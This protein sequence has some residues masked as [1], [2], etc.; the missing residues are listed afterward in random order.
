LH[1][2]RLA[3]TLPPTNQNPIDNRDSANAGLAVFLFNAPATAIATL[4]QPNGP[5]I[6]L[7]SH[8]VNKH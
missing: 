6:S 3:I 1:G 7:G 2:D 4:S 8:H 5:A